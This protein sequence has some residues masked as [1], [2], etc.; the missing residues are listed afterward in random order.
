MDFQPHFLKTDLSGEQNPSKR[1]HIIPEN[2]LNV[3]KDTSQIVQDDLNQGNL[4]NI[5]PKLDIHN[6]LL[7]IDFNH[8]FFGI[9][10]TGLSGD[11]RSQTIP[12]NVLNV[13]Q[14][15]SQTVQDDFVSDAAQD[16]LN[17]G[18]LWNILTKLDFSQ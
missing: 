5:L 7:C 18:N 12:E 2:V 13:E 9:T 17:L 10:C 6:K 14:T 3:E 1:P 11:E 16:F 8:N 15:T 4:W